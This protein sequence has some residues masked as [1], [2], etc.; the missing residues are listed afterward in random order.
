MEI[1]RVRQLVS[2]ANAPRSRRLLSS[3]SA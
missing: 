3:A 2:M 1:I